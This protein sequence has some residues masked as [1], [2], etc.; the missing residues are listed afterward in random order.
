MCNFTN[1]DQSHGANERLHETKQ[2]SSREKLLCA[3]TSPPTKAYDGNVSAM[4]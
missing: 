1:H 4:H 3:R 2:S